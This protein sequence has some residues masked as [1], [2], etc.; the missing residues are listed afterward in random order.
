MFP[1]DSFDLKLIKP[2]SANDFIQRILVPEVALQLI[3]EDRE[4][5]GLMGARAALLILRESTTYGVTM[6]PED[7]GENVSPGGGR[8]FGKTSAVGVGDKIVMERAM[9][10]RKEIESGKVE[11]FPEH[12]KEDRAAKEKKKGRGHGMK[13]AIRDAGNNS[14]QDLKLEERELPR[15][16]S[17]KISGA[18][19]D[20]DVVVSISSKTGRD[21]VNS[22][23][24]DGI[25]TISRHT[26]RIEYGKD[27]DS[28]NS[29]GQYL[30]RF[31]SKSG[32]RTLCRTQNGS[33]VENKSTRHKPLRE[34]AGSKID[35]L[36]I[37]D[38]DP[39]FPD[40]EYQE[41]YQSQTMKSLEKTFQQSRDKLGAQDLNV[42]P[43]LITPLPKSHSTVGFEV[44]ED[45]ES[46]LRPIPTVSRPKQHS[47]LALAK[48]R[49]PTAGST[50]G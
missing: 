7:S 45:G 27:L 50:N 39:C 42:N 37:S 35:P 8:K 49:A 11:A 9:K 15:R 17:R 33:S 10:R 41:T 16:L 34:I 47:V 1:P 6:F 38:S 5:K 26:K 40:S 23:Y 14:S 21:P 36:E 32:N 28:K 44:S 18:S 22:G 24:T 43:D 25:K 2:F 4:L 20:D 48:A 46:T 30:G 19:D 13:H 29:R 3:M 31:L 12:V